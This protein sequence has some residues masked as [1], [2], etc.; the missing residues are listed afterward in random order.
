[1][2]SYGNAAEL[3]RSDEAGFNHHLAKPADFMKIKEI[4]ATVS[5]KA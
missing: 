5:N 1:M 4:L 2:I 3:R